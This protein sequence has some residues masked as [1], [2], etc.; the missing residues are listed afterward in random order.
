MADRHC[1]QRAS[2]NA[3]RIRELVAPARG[4][5]QASY[6]DSCGRRTRPANTAS[7][8]RD[9]RIFGSPSSSK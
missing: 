9:Q 6:S 2:E 3:H 8:A 5:E 4:R 1:Q 7:F